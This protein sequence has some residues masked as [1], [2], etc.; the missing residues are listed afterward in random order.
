MPS[1]FLRPQRYAKSAELYDKA[2]QFIPGGVN[3]TARAAFSGWEP[4]PIFADHGTGAHVF[5]VDGNEYIDYLLGL[6]PMLL[7]HR[8]ATVT[9]AVMSRIHDV[10]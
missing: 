6:G 9:E 2:L 5:D 4:H 1:Q 8:P 7:G 10:G 3:S